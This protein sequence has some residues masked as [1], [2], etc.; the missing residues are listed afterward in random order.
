MLL[1]RDKGRKRDLI[2]ACR[3]APLKTILVPA[4]L[5]LTAPVLALDGNGMSDVWEA[6]YPAAAGFPEADPDGDGATNLAESLAWTNPAEKTSRLNLSLDTSPENIVLQGTEEQVRYQIHSTSDLRAFTRESLFVGTGEKVSA[7]VTTGGGTK[8]VQSQT[9]PILNNDNDSL[10][11]REE[12]ELGT[13]PRLTDS[14]DDGVN[15]DVEFTNG[16]NPLQKA[17]SDA[18]G[19]SDDYE[20]VIIKASG[21]DELTSLE[22]VLPGDDFDG[23]GVSNLTEFTLGSSAVVAVKTQLIQ[24]NVW[25]PE[26]GLVGDGAEPPMSMPTPLR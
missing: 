7:P 4:F 13:D 20:Q 25:D 18:D 3:V 17:D 8:F 23:D 16:T 19:M 11:D 26:G 22:T 2:A 10:D 6:I 5:V 21:G 1:F 14:D 9:A 24:N 15:D 12:A